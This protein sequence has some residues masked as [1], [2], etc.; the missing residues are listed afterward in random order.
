LKQ[1]LLS[2]HGRMLIQR[3]HPKS[4]LGSGPLTRRE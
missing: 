2:R 4:A 3:W 1:T